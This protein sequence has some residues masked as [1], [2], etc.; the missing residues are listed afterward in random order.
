MSGITYPCPCYGYLVFQEP[1]GSDDICF[2]Q[3]DLV[4]LRFIDMG[5]PSIPLI[6][7]QKN[8][9]RLGAVE[10][11]LV[12]YVRSPTADEKRDSAW[13]PIDP[14]IDV[15]EKRIRGKNRGG[16]YPKDRTDLYYWKK[17]NPQNL[18]PAA[19]CMD[20]ILQLEPDFRDQL[21]AHR[22]E[23]LPNV[24]AH[25]VMTEFSRFVQDKLIAGSY[26]KA[27]KVFEA[28]EYLLQEGN[29]EAE[30]QNAVCTCFLENLIN[31]FSSKPEFFPSFVHFLGPESRAYCRAWDEF[32]DAITPGLWKKGEFRRK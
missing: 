31:S 14:T 25:S 30:V 11:R 32:T 6:E 9:F 20:F 12:P 27:P 2:W 8:Y 23:M 3:D 28:M 1:P 21:E 13:R 4:Q 5:G 15:P 22:A 29:S 10:R 24:N 26:L 19:F 17:A 18:A 7:A 16:T